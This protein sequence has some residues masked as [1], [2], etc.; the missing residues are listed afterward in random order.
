MWTS[1]QRRHVPRSSDLIGSPGPSVLPF[2]NFYRV[3]G[4]SG[5]CFSPTGSGLSGLSGATIWARAPGQLGLY[6]KRAAVAKKSRRKKKKKQRSLGNN[7]NEG[8]VATWLRY[9]LPSLV[10]C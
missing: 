10:E 5:G 6:A 4:S 1:V 2:A 8:Y 3:G 9:V 7:N